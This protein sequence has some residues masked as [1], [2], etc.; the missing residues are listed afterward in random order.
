MTDIELA[1]ANLS[2]PLTWAQICERYPDQWVVLVEMDLIDKDPD[3]PN[4]DFHTARRSA[5]QD[6]EGAPR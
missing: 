4:A 1:V 2:E 3:A 5:W 6:A